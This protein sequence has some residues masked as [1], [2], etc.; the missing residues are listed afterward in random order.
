MGELYPGIRNRFRVF[1]IKS[2]RIKKPPGIGWLI[3]QILRFLLVSFSIIAVSVISTTV[4][5][6]AIIVT[7]RRALLVAF[8]FR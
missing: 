7:S 3:F 1:H 5:I 2:K 6:V 8:W 4:L